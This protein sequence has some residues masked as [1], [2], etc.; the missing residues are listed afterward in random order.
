MATRLVDKK[1][2]TIEIKMKVYP[3]PARGGVIFE[4]PISVINNPVIPNHW[5]DK[6][7]GVRNPPATMDTTGNLNETSNSI[8][9]KHVNYSRNSKE[10]S[11]PYTQNQPNGFDMTNKE[12]AVVV[13]VDIFRQKVAELPLVH[14]KTTWH[15]DNVKSGIYFYR[16][17]I[18]GKVLSGKIV[19]QK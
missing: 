16:I 18:E 1:T 6:S 8:N 13:I 2:F 12:G 3:N 5:E 15:T 7:A 11:H 4:L 14:E 17:E 10:M 9:S 19:V